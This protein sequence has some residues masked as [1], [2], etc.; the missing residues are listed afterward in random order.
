MHCNVLERCLLPWCFALFVDGQGSMLPLGW[1]IQNQFFLF[2][3]IFPRLARLDCFWK[4][5]IFFVWILM[6]AWVEHLLAQ[7]DQWAW[8]ASVFLS[9]CDITFSAW[10][11]IFHEG[12]DIHLSTVPMGMRGHLGI[13]CFY[14]VID[15]LFLTVPYICLRLSAGIGILLL[16]LCICL[17]QLA[18]ELVGVACF[19]PMPVYY[20]KETLR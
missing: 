6:L 7:S 4:D 12:S 13:S 14:A 18:G 17:I 16:R 15:V 11:L 2:T 5:S 10:V 1:T 20:L 19:I 8:R 3:P 9:L